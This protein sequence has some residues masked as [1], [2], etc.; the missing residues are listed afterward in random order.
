M[1]EY[2]VLSLLSARYVGLI[3]LVS[4]AA[5][6]FAASTISSIA[7]VV[8]AELE[9][10]SLNEEQFQLL[11]TKLITFS[12]QYCHGA[13]LRG[14][15]IEGTISSI[16]HIARIAHEDGFAEAIAPFLP[17]LGFLCMRST[18]HTRHMILGTICEAVK[19]V[20]RT[21]NK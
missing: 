14:M 9:E 19:V 2:E 1:H 12:L 11:I 17:L 15:G 16:R 13:L 20:T 3:P 4:P 10:P 7:E 6:S 21:W 5:C 8:E 18:G